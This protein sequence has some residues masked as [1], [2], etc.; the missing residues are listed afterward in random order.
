MMFNLSQLSKFQFL[1]RVFPL[2]VW[3][4]CSTVSASGT[5]STDPSNVSALLDRALK[6]ELSGALL[7]D[8]PEL[9]VL[10]ALYVEPPIASDELWIVKSFS[11]SAPK[12][13]TKSKSAMS[14][15]FEVSCELSSMRLKINKAGERKKSERYTFQGVRGSELLVDTSQVVKV[16]VDAV[17]KHLAQT[18]ADADASDKKELT[19]LRAEI[20]SKCR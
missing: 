2:L 17:L 11:I 16:S 5:T 7:S 1:M 3:L 13:Q 4:F 12:P 15:S 20:A 9:E 6:L 19:S 8:G 18:D 10:G 14:V